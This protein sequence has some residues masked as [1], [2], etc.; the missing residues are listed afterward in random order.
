MFNTRERLAQ[1]YSLL[2]RKIISQELGYKD[3]TTYV[4]Y[5]NDEKSKEFYN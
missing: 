4:I 2:A 1:E 3:N 5:K